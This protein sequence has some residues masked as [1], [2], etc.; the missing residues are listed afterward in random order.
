MIGGVPGTVALLFAEIWGRL[1]RKRMP[2]ASSGKVLIGRSPCWDSIEG[3]SNAVC[4]ALMHAGQNSALNASPLDAPPILELKAIPV[5]TT[6]CLCKQ[7]A[8]REVTGGRLVSQ[9]RLTATDVI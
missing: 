1:A 3:L 6:S 9:S 4:L 2:T 8:H 5:L 7:L